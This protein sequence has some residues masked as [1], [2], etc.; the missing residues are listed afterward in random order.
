M[1]ERNTKRMT[2]SQNSNSKGLLF[3]WA[4]I[5]KEYQT[6]Y[7]KWH[8][9]EH[10]PERLMI[11]GI[12]SAQRYCGIGS[13]P[14]F[15]MLYHTDDAHVMKSDAY[16]YAKNNPTPWTK[17]AIKHFRNNGRGIFGLVANAGKIPDIIP[18]YLAVFR[19]NIESGSRQEVIGW[20]AEKYLPKISKINGI[21]QGRLYE[22]DADTSE[23]VTAEQKIS[24]S[25]PGEQNFLTLYDLASLDSIQS[26]VFQKALEVPGS[27]K[28]LIGKIRDIIR[29]VY[30]LDFAMYAPP[31]A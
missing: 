16:L 17:E 15:L 26:N 2:S 9:C 20:F 18:P 6:E 5:I 27:D 30:W 21:Y 14:E 12:Q 29:E 31:S 24:G 8:N 11:P 22:I 7:R 25:R 23:I 1:A 10:I 4:D 13:S 19:F 3:I 28:K